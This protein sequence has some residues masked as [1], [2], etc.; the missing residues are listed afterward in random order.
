MQ[1]EDWEKIHDYCMEKPCVYESRPFGKYP[2]CYRISGKIFCQLSPEKEWYKATLK[3]HP[4]AA[5]FYRQAYPGI[6]VRG[7]HCPPVQQP[8]WNTVSLSEVSEELV[9]QMI[10]EA[11]AEVVGHLTKKEQKRI[12]EREQFVFQKTDGKNP[13]FVELCRRLDENL[14]E[15]V[16]KKFQR[17]KYAKYNTL[18]SIQDVLVI[19]KDGV[20]VGAGSYKF[21]DEETVEIKRVFLDQTYRDLGLGRDLLLRLEADARIKGFRYGVLETGEPLVAASALY[22]KLGYKVI[23]NYGQYK[24][25]PESVCMQ[26]KL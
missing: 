19:Y 8:Y 21:Y 25:M 18:E 12:P 17:D 15:L 22:K 6:V 14:D 24:D 13:D 1:L 10:D 11:Y 9:F 2:I 7:Y 4:D 23:P 20:P 3:T 5:D 26:K 16:G